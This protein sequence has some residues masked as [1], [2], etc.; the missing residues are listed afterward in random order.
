MPIIQR[1]T[2]KILIIFTYFLDSV[3]ALPAETVLERVAAPTT[4]RS[5]NIKAYCYPLNQN[6]IAIGEAVRRSLA[7]SK[8]D[9]GEMEENGQRCYQK[10]PSIIQRAPKSK[11]HA[12][13]KR[14][15]QK[16]YCYSTNKN[17]FAKGKPKVE[18]VSGLFIKLYFNEYNEFN[19]FQKAKRC[20]SKKPKTREDL[21]PI[22][23]REILKQSKTRSDISG[24]ATQALLLENEEVVD[25]SFCEQE[26]DQYKKVTTLSGEISDEI[27]PKVLRRMRTGSDNTDTSCRYGNLENV[28]IKRSGINSHHIDSLNFLPLSDENFWKMSLK[29]I[30]SEIKKLKY[31]LRQNKLLKTKDL[32]EKAH[33]AEDNRLLNKQ[34]NYYNQLKILKTNKPKII[35][36]YCK[37]RKILTDSL[38]VQ[39]KI[40]SPCLDVKN[41]PKNLKSELISRTKLVNRLRCVPFTVG[42]TASSIILDQ[43]LQ[44]KLEGF[45]A[46][47]YNNDPEEGAKYIE[48]CFEQATAECFCSTCPPK[49]L[50]TT[51][52]KK[53]SQSKNIGEFKEE[54]S[55]IVLNVNRKNSCKKD[56]LEI[57][58]DKKSEFLYQ[59]VKKDL[60]ALGTENFLMARQGIL[61]STKPAKEK[62]DALYTLFEKAG[63][64]KRP[65]LAKEL[66]KSAIEVAKVNN[67]P[68]LQELSDKLNYAEGNLH[69]LTH[70]DALM[71]NLIKNHEKQM[72]LQKS[73][74]VADSIHETLQSKIYQYFKQKPKAKEDGSKSYKEK[75]DRFCQ[76]TKRFQREGTEEQKGAYHCYTVGKFLKKWKQL[77]SSGGFSTTREILAEIERN[78]TLEERQGLYFF[79]KPQRFMDI[80]EFQ[81]NFSLRN[82]INPER[83]DTRVTQETEPQTFSDESLCSITYSGYR[84][85]SERRSCGGQCHLDPKDLND[86]LYHK[87]NS[88]TASQSRQKPSKATCSP[89][90]YF[91][92][93]TRLPSFSFIET[94]NL[95]HFK[96]LNIIDMSNYLNDAIQKLE[97]LRP[98]EKHLA[99]IDYF[100]T[101]LKEVDKQKDK[102]Q[103]AAMK[104]YYQQK[105]SRSWLESPPKNLYFK[106]MEAKAAAKSPELKKQI[107]DT[108]KQG[109][110]TADSLGG[111]F[112][113][114]AHKLSIT[115]L[116]TV[117]KTGRFNMPLSYVDRTQNPLSE[118][119]R[120]TLRNV[121][122]GV[123]DLSRIRGSVDGETVSESV[124]PMMRVGMHKSDDNREPLFLSP[125]HNFILFPEERRNKP[126]FESQ[127]ADNFDRSFDFINTH[128]DYGAWAGAITN[129][130]LYSMR[131]THEELRPVIQK[132]EDSEGSASRKAY[133][134]LTGLL[135]DP[136]S[137]LLPWAGAKVIQLGAR[138]SLI[139]AAAVGG[140]DLLTATPRI[141]RATGAMATEA[142]GFE[143]AHRV[144][145]DLTTRE[146]ADW[147]ATDIA[148]NTFWMTLK[149]GAAHGMTKALG[150]IFRTPHFDK[151][152]KR[153]G[154]Q[155]ILAD[156]TRLLNG[157]GQYAEFFGSKM[158]ATLG[159]YSVGK[160][161]HMITENQHDSSFTEEL[162]MLIQFE[163]GTA[164]P[165]K[166]IGLLGRNN[167]SISDAYKKALKEKEAYKRRNPDATKDQLLS[168]M[169]DSFAKAKNGIS[170]S[171]KRRYEKLAKD[172]SSKQLESSVAKLFSEY[173]DSGATTTAATAP[174]GNL[175]LKREAKRKQRS[176][177][178]RQKTQS[179]RTKEQSSQTSPE[180]ASTRAERKP[181]TKPAKRSSSRERK[182]T[183]ERPAEVLI[184]EAVKQKIPKDIYKIFE[185]LDPKIQR[186]I[187]DKYPAE[188]LSGLRLNMF[189]AE[190]IFEG[191]IKRGEIERCS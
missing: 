140:I 85:I 113:L 54:M 135:S 159:F 112:N 68:R 168:V 32:D 154:E 190:I 183:S 6:K 134:A 119:D 90:A 105:W 75:V 96:E 118:M 174:Q 93:P 89:H 170:A 40:F 48:K 3:F 187:L 51:S 156:G 60:S 67:D 23:I 61:D 4:P 81:R 42:V 39:L 102:F 145:Q 70:D 22:S 16:I 109:L 52:L 27:D 162:I 107:A 37:T 144:I 181:T 111:H 172:L 139:R 87:V 116:Y 38:D 19:K 115:N 80:T 28:K 35:K 110:L 31:R 97:S 95:C 100:K 78:G 163:L 56:I 161:A 153:K 175:E 138:A 84:T 142:F 189:K 8:F 149:F 36:N 44:C 71:G 98:K 103:S 53:I 69:L 76:G 151:L 2:L 152:F 79:S 7:P 33:I 182:P 49:S 9:G 114:V 64:L 185:T 148:S 47:P 129:A 117:M 122:V 188:N 160:I 77:L 178:Q 171:S 43:T 74:L 166:T 177:D 11:R 45:S 165:G 130:A 55:V 24:S 155:V 167:K 101:K 18:K 169:F 91:P 143:I 133:Y 108:L 131:A 17:G 186:K 121:G 29:K 184:S 180:V 136:T 106:L 41:K 157:P 66:L 128:Q 127:L 5:S 30:K 146:G 158:A 99:A 13:T 46:Y 147:D 86:I 150:K 25:P 82:L 179:S 10:K 173:I 141:V 125:L 65:K 123:D 58:Q 126:G 72:D 12:L 124:C 15:N 83:L 62:I 50:D 26:S 88:G 120:I 164:I 21:A 176:K 92:Y 132:I 94:E 63:E 14:K 73:Y 104:L 59:C 57:V 20:Y 191:K 137:I 34:L 1:M